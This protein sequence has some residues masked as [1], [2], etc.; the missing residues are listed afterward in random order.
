MKFVF[1][2]HGKKEGKQG[3][4][5]PLTEEGRMQARQAGEYLKSQGL[6]P[7]WVCHT[8][9]KRTKE[10]AEGV[11]EALGVKCPVRPPHGWDIGGTRRGEKEELRAAIE[12]E[13][14]GFFAAAPHESSVTM[15][16]GHNTQQGPLRKQ[17]GFPEIPKGHRGCVLVLEKKPNG[18]W[19]ADGHLP[20]TDSDA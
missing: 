8:P 19:E 17:F 16:V 20:G 7:D 6:T 5:G 9:K 12:R 11:L 14:E 4:N 1:V 18:R 13:I 15:F 10:T 3:E 2:R